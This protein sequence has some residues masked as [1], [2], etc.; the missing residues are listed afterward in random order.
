MK[1]L[2]ATSVLS[3]YQV[4]VAVKY[5]KTMMR[6]APWST[7]VVDATKV[8]LTASAAVTNI[9][10]RDD[11]DQA[12]GAHTHNLALIILEGEQ[13]GDGVAESYAPLGSGRVVFVRSATPC[14][15]I[16]L[17]AGQAGHVGVGKEDRAVVAVEAGTR[18]VFEQFAEQHVLMLRGAIEVGSHVRPQAFYDH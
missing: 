12:G 8:A 9:F 6:A 1:G 2:T 4:S 17:R 11:N 14:Q 13:A 18:A 10:G 16:V 15:C 7:L 3:K 5:G